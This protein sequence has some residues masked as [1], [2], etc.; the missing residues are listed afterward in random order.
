MRD[1]GLVRQTTKL[2]PRRTAIAAWIWQIT[3]HG[4]HTAAPMVLVAGSTKQHTGGQADLLLSLQQ[5]SPSD[6]HDLIA[7]TAEGLAERIDGCDQPATDC[8]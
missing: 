8:A 7:I 4:D 1:R 6:M 2:D 3:T 5:R